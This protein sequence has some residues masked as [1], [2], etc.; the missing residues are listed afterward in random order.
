[1]SIISLASVVGTPVGIASASFTLIFSLTTGLIKKLSSITRNKKKNHYK[2]LMLAK[3][4]LSSF[5][6]LISQARLDMQISHEKFV[7]VL[8]YKDKYK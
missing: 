2:I 7:I 5:E 1:M 4:K 8:K 3:T 6:N